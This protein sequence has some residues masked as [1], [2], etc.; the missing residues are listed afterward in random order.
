MNSWRTIQRNDHVV[1]VG[2]DL[3]SLGLK[4]QASSQKGDPYAFPPKHLCQREQVCVALG[5]AAGEHSPLDAQVAE[6]LDLT[7]EILRGDFLWVADLPDVAHHA[8]ATALI[9]GGNDNDRKPVN[10]MPGDF[11]LI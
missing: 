9:V 10:E 11:R 3:L 5:L 4:Q 7:L 1:N 2:S 8:S 6:R